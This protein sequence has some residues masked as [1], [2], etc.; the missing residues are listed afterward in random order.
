[1]TLAEFLV[2]ADADHETALSQAR[3]YTV[4]QPVFITSNT[5]TVYVVQAGLYDVFTDTA[6]DEASPVRGICLA[7][8]DRLRGQSEFNLSELLPLGQA[9]LQML[10]ALRLGLPQHAA[11]IAALRDY[12][13]S[14]S[15]QQVQPFANV[16]LHDVLIA[17]DACPRKAV[18]ATGQWL[19]VTTTADCELHNPRIYGTNP[20]TQRT[21]ILGNIRIQSA[22]VYEFKMPTHYLQHTGLCIDDAYGVI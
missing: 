2:T 17:R 22:G 6:N 9:N 21:E 16:T 20:R 12:L 1:M 4:T 14:L 3:A 7:L 5:M 11:K 18:T 13:A 10:E 19:T 15:N 8:M